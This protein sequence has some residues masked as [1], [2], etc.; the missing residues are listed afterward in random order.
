MGPTGPSW[1]IR[2]TDLPP[3]RRR[4]SAADTGL[5]QTEGTL[6]PPG[7]W[8]NDALRAPRETSARASDEEPPSLLRRVR[9]PPPASRTAG[10]GR[11][12]RGGARGLSAGWGARGLPSQ[13]RALS[14]ER[15]VALASRAFSGEREGL[16]LA[17]RPSARERE[18]SAPRN[19]EPSAEDQKES[20]PGK[21]PL[22]AARR[23]VVVDEL[24]AHY[25]VM[26]RRGAARLGLR[27]TPLPPANQLGRELLRNLGFR[28]TGAQ[29]RV[30][31]EVLTD[32]DS[33]VPMMRL[34][35]GDVGSGR[36]S[37][38]LRAIRAAESEARRRC[39]ADGILADSTSR[40]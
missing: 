12:L 34:W 20:A 3:S 22:E 14:G 33:P 23:R 15:G 39:G 40:P 26:K 10:G 4:R 9:L 2:I 24:L 28:L 38:P 32:L 21:D 19:K 8:I 35:Q 30:A 13:A 36:R 16:P 25:L 29:A 31:R 17:T 37:S 6:H 18:G 5:P 11:A 7:Y 1:R 27:T